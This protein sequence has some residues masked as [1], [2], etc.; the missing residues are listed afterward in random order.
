MSRAKSFFTRL[1]QRSRQVLACFVLPCLVL[2]RLCCITFETAHADEVAPATEAA[3]ADDPALR[4]AIMPLVLAHR[5]DV[6]VAIEHLKTKEA[7]RYH[8]DTAMPTASLIKLPLM[9]AVYQATARGLLDLGQH[10]ELK[11][12]DK[13]PGSGILTEHFSDG[14]SLSLRDYIRL[15]IR[16]SDNTATNIVVDQVGL[17]ATAELMESIGLPNT[18]LHSKVYRRETSI[19]PERSKQ[20]GIGSTTANEMVALL[21]MLN[22]EQLGDTTSTQQ[23]LEHMAA[24]DDRSKLARYLPTDVKLFHKTGSLNNCRTDAGLFETP[25]GPVAVCLLTNQNT[26]QSWNDSNEAEL[27][28]AQ[29]GRIVVERFSGKAL[30]LV[31]EI[32]LHETPA[33]FNARDAARSKE[34]APAASDPPSVTC[35]AWLVADAETGVELGGWNAQEPR[36]PASTTKIMTALLVAELIA[37][38]PQVSDE[39][40][41]FSQHAD[42]TIGSSCTLRAGEQLPVSELLYGLLLP[43]GNDAATALAEHLGERLQPSSLAKCENPIQ[44]FVARMNLRARELGMTAT[45][46]ENPHGLTEPKHLSSAA[47]LARLAYAASQDSLIRKIVST[48]QHACTVGSTQGY[49]RIVAWH[50]TNTL[51]DIEG[52]AGMKT[53]T[54]EAAGACLVATGSRAGKSR[55]VVVL[56]SS[57]SRARVADVQNLFRW[58]LTHQP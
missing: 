40:V 9:V 33:E 57:D 31:E 55:I 21:R 22:Q 13:V 56:G 34:P 11:A 14:A 49:S 46:F 39:I 15:M 10:I 26:D 36:P 3:R 53:G 44:A 41:T 7:F 54:T 16:D 58:S 28:C 17:A 20:Y 51:L 32:A 48:R 30:P 5:G 12:E 38:D 1:A 37:K 25:T 8:A 4:D 45:N 6:A 42:D 52:Y 50:N 35:K 19:F 23:M 2:S 43:S 47:D 18:K 24:C 27:L 29:I